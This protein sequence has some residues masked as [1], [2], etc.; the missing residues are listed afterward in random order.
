[1]FGEQVV[2]LCQCHSSSAP[3]LRHHTAFNQKDKAANPGNAHKKTV[4]LSRL[5]RAVLF[6][7]VLSTV[8]VTA[9]SNILASF[10]GGHDIESF[11]RVRQS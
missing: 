1:M 3:Y 11:S 4:L 9:D 8:S 7:S 10:S 5:Q 6:G 2:F